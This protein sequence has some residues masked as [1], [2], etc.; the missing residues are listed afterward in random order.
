M[1]FPYF[2]YGDLGCSFL[3]PMLM[4][5]CPFYC[6]CRFIILFV[7]IYCHN[8]VIVALCEQ[9]LFDFC[10]FFFWPFALWADRGI[11]GLPFRFYYTQL[12]TMLR[13][14]STFTDLHNGNN[15]RGYSHCPLR[16]TMYMYVCLFVFSFHAVDF[17]HVVISMSCLCFPCYLKSCTC[18]LWICTLPLLCIYQIHNVISV[19]TISLI[20]WSFIVVHRCNFHYIFLFRI[21]DGYGISRL[22]VALLHV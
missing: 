3:A 9:R 5:F 2:S 22:V 17:Y 1:Q 12:K 8:T 13:S 11:P 6:C 20:F 19:L 7:F 10:Y 16:S 21:C 15:D 18:R 4:E 14:L